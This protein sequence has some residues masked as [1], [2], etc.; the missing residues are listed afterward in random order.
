M[1]KKIIAG[2]LLICC[3]CYSQGYRNPPSGT[4][5]LMNGG[6]FVAQADDPSA[7]VLNPAGLAFLKQNQFHSGILFL[8]SETKFLGNNVSTSK[9]NNI[10]YLGNI[11]ASYAPKK[12]NIGFGFG[13]TS[14]YGQK[15]QWNKK[16][17]EIHWAYNVPY[18]GEMKFITFTPA[19]AFAPTPYLGLG[20]G[21]DIHKSMVETRQ[22]IPWSFI[23]ATPDGIAVLKGEDLAISLRIGI[24]FN[25]QK[26]SFGFVWTSPFEMDYSGTFSMTNFPQTLPGFLNGI[27]PTV[28]SRFK[29]KFPEIYSLG[30]RWKN[31][32]IAF[33][34]GAEF[35]K[36]SCLEKIVVDAGPNSILIPTFIKNWKDVWTFS[37]GLEYMINSACAINFGIGLIETPVPDR[38]FEPTLP[39]SDRIVYS[40]GTSINLKPGKLSLFY[41]QNNFKDRTILQGGFTDGVYKSSGSFIGCGFTAKI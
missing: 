36:Y 17:T 24:L 1:A 14:P 32:K 29:I 37:G 15:T 7:C 23:T 9:E 22:S 33:Q 30:Y 2:I 6:A 8:F 39:D 19:M 18:Y 10:A 26:H 16:F 13:I 21:I 34:M 35:V 38:T 28:K 31:E 40:V 25:K 27:Q 20:Y 11:Y 12:S 5:A 3:I 4:V 41:M